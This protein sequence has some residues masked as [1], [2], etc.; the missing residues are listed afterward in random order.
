MPA[1]RLLQKEAAWITVD[2]GRESKGQRLAACAPLFE[3]KRV[4]FPAKSVAA[5]DV[6][7]VK[8]QLTGY[9]PPVTMTRWTRAPTPWRASKTAPGTFSAT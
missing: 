3:A 7:A 9:P 6:E 5:F 1:G 2:P 4:V 8:T